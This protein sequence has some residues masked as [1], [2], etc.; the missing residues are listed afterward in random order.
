MPTA[1]TCNTNAANVMIGGRATD[2]LCG[3]WSYQV[4]GVATQ[5][6]RVAVDPLLDHSCSIVVG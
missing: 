5:R 3:A 6:K 2:L 4:G 1:V